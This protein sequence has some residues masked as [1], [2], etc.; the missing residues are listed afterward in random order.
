MS[1]LSG[2]VFIVT[3]GESGIGQAI[4]M[5]AVRDG[6]NIVIAGIKILKKSKYKTNLRLKW[7]WS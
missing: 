1:D 3:G 4:A 7:G 6:A 2:K 5:R